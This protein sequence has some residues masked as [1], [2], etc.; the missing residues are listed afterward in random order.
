M[1]L[2]MNIMS[3]LANVFHKIHKKLIGLYPCHNKMTKRQNW[4]WNGEMFSHILFS[5]AVTHKFT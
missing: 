3:E 5:T 2:S 1:I 4:N